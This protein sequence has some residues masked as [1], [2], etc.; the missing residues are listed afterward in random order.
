[1]EKP[2]LVIMAAGIGSRYGGLKQIDPVGPCGELIIDYS[3]YYA[4]K[5]GFEK[6]VFIITKAIES[7]FRE[8]I[9]DRITRF[10]KTEY[11][12][13]CPDD[14]PAG[15][16]LPAERTKPLGTAHAI[17]CSR[18]LVGGNFAAINADD[19]YGEEAFRLLYSELTRPRE[20]FPYPF[21]MVGYRLANTVTDNGHVARG[22]CRLDGEGYLAKVTERTH[23]EKRDG[24]I[25]FT[26]NGTDWTNLAPDTIVSMNCWGFTPELFGEIEGHFAQFWHSEKT[27]PLK[28]E[29]Y[30]PWVV[31][32]LIQEQKAKVRV[33]ET[34]GRWYGVTYRADKAAVVA[35][36]RELILAGKY[37]ERLW[38]N[39]GAL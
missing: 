34:E 7:D 31:D 11:A 20:K 37:P 23:I 36:I 22:V 13:Q 14:L 16:A 33:L 15:F 10:V 17:W 32:R 21:C 4:L 35:A 5:A 19:Y 29:Y 24:G 2:T 3:I 28:S 39:D 12:Y 26:E 18:E 1:M 6:V 27:D 8:I 25:C 38:G 30:L 9:G